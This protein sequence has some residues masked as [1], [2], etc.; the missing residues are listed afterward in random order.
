MLSQAAAQAERQLPSDLKKKADIIIII[1][2]I[3]IMVASI[4]SCT[5]SRYLRGHGLVSIFKGLFHSPI[6]LPKGPGLQV[7]VH[8]A[9]NMF[10]GKT[11]KS[12]LKNRIAP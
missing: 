6:P 10:Q 4:T 5:S 9:G 1:I 12:A 8:L 3:I 7:S 2:I 11:I